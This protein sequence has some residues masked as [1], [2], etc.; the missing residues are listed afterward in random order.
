MNSLCN[1][2][3][4]NEHIYYNNAAHEALTSANHQVERPNPTLNAN[5]TAPRLEIHTQNGE[6][7]A[8]N[9]DQNHTRYNVRLDEARRAQREAR[10]NPELSTNYEPIRVNPELNANYESVNYVEEENRVVPNSY[11]T[12][13]QA[14]TEGVEGDDYERPDDVG[15]GNGVVN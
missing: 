1:R 4:R 2:Q 14:N 11:T 7:E 5:N 15:I 10:V 6:Y 3:T 13:A 8:I 12:L 9:M